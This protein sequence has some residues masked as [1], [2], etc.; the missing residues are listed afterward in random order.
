MLT[1]PAP[2]LHLDWLQCQIKWVNK[3]KPNYASFYDVKRLEFGTRH[4]R[5]IEE[6][7]MNKKRI[8]TI[9]SQPHSNI[10]DP[11]ALIVK[12]D[13][14]VCY[15]VNMRKIISDFLAGNGFE[16]VSF[17]RVD[18]C[19]DFNEFDNGMQCEK[20]IKSYIGRR[21]L[22]LGKSKNVAYHFSQGK[23]SH[24]SKGLKFGSNLS[25]VTAY[26]YDKTL[27][28]ESVK[29]KPWIYKA[30]EKGGLDVKRHVWRLEFSMKS[31]GKL[32]CNTETGELDLF[33][34]LKLLEFEY[35]YKCF[36]T[37]YEKYFHFVW[38]DG[39]VRK[40][41]MRQ[42]KMFKHLPCDDVLVN[43]EQMRD[44][45][46]SKKIFIKKLHEMNNEMRGRDFHMNVYMTEFQR[47]LIEDSHLQTWAMKNGLNS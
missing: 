15:A 13:N 37:L 6:V 34:S 39:Q 42:V 27:E 7:Y 43:A 38:N 26:I 22:R 32:V 29:W 35:I 8:A 41:R 17:S 30:W 3:L 46:R 11:D 44:A 36:Y 45:D 21:C 2:V 5:C 10:L 19:A 9:A 16:F 20:F 23:E 47:Q 40:D 12:F 25:E 18:F 24:V 28:M 4:F 14:W 33:L 31:G 1:K